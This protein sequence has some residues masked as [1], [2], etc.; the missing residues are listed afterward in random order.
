MTDKLANVFKTKIWEATNISVHF[1]FKDEMDK[2]VFH[3]S[4]VL[5]RHSDNESFE[6]PLFFSYSRNHKLLP[7]LISPEI[8]IGF[9]QEGQ[10]KK[11][12]YCG[13]EANSSEVKRIKSYE[14]YIEEARENN[15]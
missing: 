9:A 13:I 3:K 1:V 11:M 15:N 2:E 6:R 8:G 7:M 4:Y 14:I 12:V 10:D 5:H